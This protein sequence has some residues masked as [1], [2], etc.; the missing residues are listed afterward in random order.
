MR[1]SSRSLGAIL[2]IRQLSRQGPRLVTYISI[3][4]VQGSLVSQ[5]GDFISI[6]PL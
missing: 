4:L 6:M 5:P 3:V 1:W 2:Q